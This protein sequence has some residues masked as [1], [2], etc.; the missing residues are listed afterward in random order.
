M[1][2][3]FVSIIVLFIFCSVSYAGYE[4][5]Q[6]VQNKRIANGKRSGSL[7][8]REAKNLDHGQAKVKRKSKRFEQSKANVNADGKVTKK[9]RRKLA[10]QRVKLIKIQNKQS[11]KIQNK[12]MN[13]RK[14][15]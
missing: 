15:R 9:E 6:D 14:A 11:K 7:N 4:K 8:K 3:R 12:K 1:L 2:S 10:K 13:R 5:R